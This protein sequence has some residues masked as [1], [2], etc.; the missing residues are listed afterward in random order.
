MSQPVAIRLPVSGSIEVVMSRV[1]GAQHLEESGGLSAFVGESMITGA[2]LDAD[3]G[4][5]MQVASRNEGA[6]DEN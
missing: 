6:R 4:R 1:A 3:G 5:Y 2:A